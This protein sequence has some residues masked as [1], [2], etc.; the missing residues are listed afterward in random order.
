MEAQLVRERLEDERRRLETLRAR[1]GAMES[2]QASFAELSS[3]DQHP[4]EIATETFELEKEVTIQ[5][6][7][8]GQLAEVR[9]ALRKLDEGAY[10]VCEACGR[11]IAEARLEAKPS[12]RFC[13]EDQVRAERE[14][15]ERRELH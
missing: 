4:A 5:E 6:M 12:A 13:L 15:N 3:I 14:V 8:E 2:Q 11:P 7:V 9:D 1:H 10:G